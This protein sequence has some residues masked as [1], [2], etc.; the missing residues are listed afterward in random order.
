L[1]GSRSQVLSFFSFGPLHSTGE[2]KIKNLNF[3]TGR[4]RKR[5]KIPYKL[6]MY[7]K[8]MMTSFITVQQPELL[9][10]SKTIILFHC[11]A[12]VGEKVHVSYFINL[13]LFLYS[14]NVL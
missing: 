1:K 10:V 13:I 12:M 14:T 9:S 3:Q 6:K 8:A 5:R 7:C 2:E 4:I 11:V